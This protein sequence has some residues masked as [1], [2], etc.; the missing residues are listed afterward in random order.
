MNK[1]NI[2]KYAGAVLFFLVLAYAFVPQVLGGKIVNQPDTSGFMGMAH[3]MMS[4]NESHPEDPTAWTGSMFSGMPTTTIH[5]SN[6]DD[7]TQKLYDFLLWGKRPATYLFAAL[8]GAFLLMLSLGINF[9]PAI[10]GAIAV[11]FCSYNMQIIQVGHNTKMQ[12]IAFLPW[13]LAAVIYTYKSALKEGSRFKDYFSKTCLGAVLFGLSLSLELKANHQQI[14]YYL[15]I[16]IFIYVLS[17]LVGILRKPSK[18][19]ALKKFMLASGLL[20]VLGITGI[21]SNAGKLL[22]VYEY[23]PYSMRGGSSLLEEKKD[24]SKGLTLDYATAWSYGWQELPNMLIPNFNGGASS[25]AVKPSKS[26]TYKLLRQYGQPNAKEI[27]SSL[28]TY[29]GP[30]PFTAGPMYMGAVTIFLFVLGLGLCKG[31]DKWWLLAGTITAVLLGVGSHFMWFTKLWYDYAPFYN[32]FRTVSMALVSLQFTLPMLGFLALD[33]ILKGSVERKE[34]ERKSLAS[35]AITGGICL[36]FALIPSLAGSFASGSDAGQQEILVNALR[37]DRRYLLSADAW[38]SLLLI[39]CAFALLWWSARKREAAAPMK[40]RSTIAGVLICVLVLFDLFSA[41]KRYL[42]DDDFITKREFD[43]AFVQ[44]NADKIILEDKDPSYRVLDLS[45]S[46]FNDSRSSYWHK[47]IGGY[48]PAK[49]QKYQDLITAYIQ[50]EIS[51]ILSKTKNAGTIAEFEQS[52]P[53]TPILNALNTRYIIVDGNVSPA[54][55][56]KAL[57]N[58]WFVKQAVK[59]ES[60]K[61]AFAM[62]GSVDLSATAIV[63]AQEIPT[64]GSGEGIIELVSYKPNELCYKYSCAS[65]EIAVFSEVFYPKGWHAYLDGDK[66]ADVAVFCADWTL[67]AAVLPTG[68]HELTMRFDPKSY[69]IGA[70]IS[71]ASSLLLFMMLVL[72]FIPI[73]NARKQ[74]LKYEK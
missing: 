30:Q 14:T 17:L 44:R 3:E 12:A 24:G 4:Y 45:V 31:K 60:P 66:S 10:G 7:L 57:G 6:K 49:I 74:K 52:L 28:P 50:P 36:I 62:L 59:A 21:A 53:E 8:L 40:S 68:E 32:K 54:L 1:K 5:M 37:S 42:K 72:C 65:D 33:R 35:L 56:T 46:T 23:A 19:A 41:G 47:S 29:W 67:R 22:P 18:A 69:S 63:E 61:E 9:L 39:V 11:A 48:S 70:K 26:E 64:S 13:V 71:K 38:R 73:I 51:S 43:K 27:C 34:F 2:L 16:L 55:N 20:L 15:G 25:S 58:A